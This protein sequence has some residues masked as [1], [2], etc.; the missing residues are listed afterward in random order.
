MYLQQKIS[1]ARTKEFE[2]EVILDKAINLFRDK[3]F[4]ATFRTRPGGWA[5]HQQIQPVRYFWR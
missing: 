3:G 1:M 5:W 2:E 4:N